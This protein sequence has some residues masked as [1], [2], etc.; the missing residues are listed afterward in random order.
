M[1]STSWL[2]W[3]KEGIVEALLG[4][5]SLARKGWKIIAWVAFCGFLFSILWIYGFATEEDKSPGKKMRPTDRLI[6]TRSPQNLSVRQEEDKIDPAERKRLEEL[7][8]RYP[9]LR[10]EPFVRPDGLTIY[11]GLVTLLPELE[12]LDKESTKN[13]YLM[14]SGKEE[15][16]DEAVSEFLRQNADLLSKISEASS[17]SP[18]DVDGF[19]DFS[20]EC[21]EILGI[22]LGAKLL[23]LQ[24][25]S[26][27]RSNDHDLAFEALRVFDRFRKTEGRS[28]IHVLVAA[29]VE[30]Q[31]T[32]SLSH[33]SEQGYA[34]SELVDA[35]PWIDPRAA[36]LRAM[37]GEFASK[38]LFLEGAKNGTL[39]GESFEPFE[40]VGFIEGLAHTK[41][42]ELIAQISSEQVAS[43]TEAP[44]WE[45]KNIDSIQ[46]VA[47]LTNEV[48]LSPIDRQFLELTTS[49]S[50]PKAFG[51][52][53]GPQEARRLE[54]TVLSAYQ[55]ALRAG[56]EPQV[57]EDLIPEF[58]PHVPIDPWTGEDLE[59]S[60][61]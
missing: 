52:S 12:A 22:S 43:V 20:H 10:P 39:S 3:L 27:I 33:L 23:N 21:P 36:I 45:Q 57:I 13:L 35:W 8:Q 1:G 29:N 31:V 44:W 18:L 2:F 55:E 32:R 14:A 48:D 26:A 9:M 6:S 24:L 42:Q 30:D 37:R 51:R 5:M 34:V 41:L 58:L 46:Q 59:L 11:E 7:Y 50:S 56:E 38:V 28:H 4:K 61:D 49:V 16:D 53:F 19:M 40:E 15:W 17:F 25:H 54:L 47:E 60:T